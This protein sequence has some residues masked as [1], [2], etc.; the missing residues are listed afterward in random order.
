[1]VIISIVLAGA[2]YGPVT[3][4]METNQFVFWASDGFYENTIKSL[5]VS[6]LYDSGHFGIPIYFFTVPLA[7]V[8]VIMLVMAVWSWKNK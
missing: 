3:K 2:S 4:M 6:S 7:I 1:M 5:L 8:F